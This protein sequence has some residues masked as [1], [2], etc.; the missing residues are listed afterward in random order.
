MVNISMV[1]SVVL[2]I[3]FVISVTPNERTTTKRVL[4]SSG[5]LTHV[6]RVGFSHHAFWPCAFV[7]DLI[8]V[9]TH[10]GKGYTTHNGHEKAERTRKALGTRHHPQ[11]LANSDLF[12]LVGSFFL[13]FHHLPNS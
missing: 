9:L 3:S 5:D 12:I 8:A 2:S 7:Y 1:M 13:N 6:F 10:R 4:K 11:R